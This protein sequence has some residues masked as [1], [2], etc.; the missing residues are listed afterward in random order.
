MRL[1]NRYLL[2]VALLAALGLWILQVPAQTITPDQPTPTPFTFIAWGDSRDS[3]TG[4]PVNTDVLSALSQQVVS[5]G[6]SPTFTIFA[7]DLCDSFDATCISTGTLGWKY[8]IN[9]AGT[10]NLFNIT[11][12]FRGNH[13]GDATA[14]DQYFSVTNTS[15]QTVITNI[16]GTSTGCYTTDGT[17]CVRTYSFDYSNAHIV[18][19]D[20]PRGNI[21]GMTRG[22][23][24]WLDSDL[25][26]AESRG[27]THTF[28]LDHGPFY[29]V[30][31]HHSR[32]SRAL[33]NVM[34]K[35]SSISATFHGHEHVMAYVHVDGTHIRGVMHEFEEFVTGGAGAPLYDCNTGR[36]LDDATQPYPDYC[37]GASGAFLGGGG[38]PGTTGDSFG[39]MS[40]FVDGN[41]FT[42]SLYFKSPAGFQRSGTFTK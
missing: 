25:T 33:I 20:L 19:I 16:G 29:F 1:K 23:I 24:A 14:W 27:V 34:N 28:I 9:G 3:T 21:S 15:R 41:S 8:A 26:A 7:G 37:E 39:F 17:A 35:H 18:G 31:G 30:D 2:V 40:V 36:L 10:N 22:Q 38:A 42:V 12:P 32:P 5:L 13:D 11:F 4:G 6:L